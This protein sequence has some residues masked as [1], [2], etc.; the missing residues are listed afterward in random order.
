MIRRQSPSSINTYIQCP[1]KYY[2]VYELK[3]PTKPSIHL[4]RGSVAHLA[5]ENLFKL[6]PEGIADTYKKDLQVII[7]T[8]LKRFWDEAKEDFDAL[9]M[10]EDELQRYYQETQ[11]ML[12]NWIGQ[13]T[14]RITLLIDKGKS[15]IDAWKEIRPKTEILYED[16]ALNVKGFID[17]IEE[18][19]GKIRLMDYKTSKRA[20]ITDAYKLQL[21][22]YALMYERKHGKKPEYVGIYFLKDN[23]HL[24]RV[25]DDLIKNALFHIEQI[26][27]STQTSDI[28]DYPMKKSGLCKWSTGQCDFYDYC[29]KGKKIP[30][31]SS[32]KLIKK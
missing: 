13:L 3:L 27:A 10:K 15:F 31:K 11:F 7:L 28:D 14:K 29:F 18:S 23:E 22:I 21:G 25:D 4:V 1:R 24:L 9:K 32:H 8:L 19:N 26:H 12:L 2:F 6:E 17:A 20:H 30:P 16:E 5:L